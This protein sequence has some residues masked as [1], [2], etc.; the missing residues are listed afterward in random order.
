MKPWPNGRRTPYTAT[1]IARC[2][3]IRCD[4]PARYQWRSCA[5]DRWRP[6]CRGCDVLLNAL[7]LKFMRDPERA[8]KMARYTTR[9]ARANS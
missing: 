7:V 5:D 6:V 3:C 4:R 9:V 2:R 8:E 1:G